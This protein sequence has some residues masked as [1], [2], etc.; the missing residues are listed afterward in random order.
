MITRMSE[1]EC[2]ACQGTL[3][4]DRRVLPDLATRGCSSCGLLLSV[5]ER[6]GPGISEF[7]LVDEDAY[8]RSVGA[9]RRRQAA[10]ILAPL[11]RL[12]APRAAVLDVGCSFGFFLEEARLEGFRIQGVEPD[13]QAYAYARALLG[14][15][16]VR[17][18]ILDTHTSPPGSANVITTLDVIEHI[19]V[20]EHEEFAGI[21]RHVLMPGGVWVIK[22]PATEGLFYKLSDLL[23]RVYPRIGESL[24]RRMWQTRYEYPHLVYFSLESLSRWLHRFGFVVLDHRYL[25]EVDSRTVVDRLTTDGDIGKLK[26][27]LAAPAVL[28]VTLVD[29]LRRRS[30][31]LVLFA[32]P[33]P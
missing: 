6:S 1:R 27:Y 19:P 3:F 20:E 23:V 17:H 11:K 10:K 22:V 15:D 16:V 12:V 14:E 13:P 2:P 32:R 18:G 31:A 4:V 33:R 29:S 9:A 28:G 26:A 24:I 21:V 7:A 25:P 5:I 30:D 8:L